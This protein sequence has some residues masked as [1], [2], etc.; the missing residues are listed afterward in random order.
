MRN[1]AR[2]RPRAWQPPGFAPIS[3]LRSWPWTVRLTL[4]LPRPSPPWRTA[5]VERVNT[6]SG[7]LWRVRV[8]PELQRANAE[9]LQAAVAQKLRVEG[10]VVTHP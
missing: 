6:D 9:K 1:A 4:R 5:Y 3:R 10:M 2:P 7:P 8:G